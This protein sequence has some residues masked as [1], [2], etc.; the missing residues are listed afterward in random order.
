MEPEKI[1][2]AA[3]QLFKDDILTEKE[4]R[5]FYDRYAGEDNYTMLRVIRPF[6]EKKMEELVA[7]GESTEDFSVM[8]HGY[9]A[10]GSAEILNEYD[11]LCDVIHRCVE[12]P[13]M[14]DRYDDLVGDLLTADE[15]DD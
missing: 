7:R 15:E 13:A 11:I 5:V 12:N 2:T 4:Y 3:L 1:D 10:F 14:A 8:L 9:N 6:L